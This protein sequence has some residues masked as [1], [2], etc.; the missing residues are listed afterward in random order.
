MKNIVTLLIASVLAGTATSQLRADAWPQW[1]GPNRNFI[2][3]ARGLADAWPASGPRVIW[4]RPLGTGHS[5]IVAADGR[6]FTMYRVGNGRTRQGPWDAEEIVVALDAATGRTIWEY[7][8]PSKREDFSFGA[9]PHS[10]PI[11]V[12]ERL[13]T[14]GTNKQLHAFEARTGKLLWSH[15]LVKEFNSPTL[16]IRPVVK[17]GYGCSPIAF[18]DTII[19]SA[20]GPGQSVMAFRQRDGSVAWKSGD[21]LTSEAP[22]ILIDVAGT[23]QLVVF[24][25]GTV[26]GLDPGTGAVLWSHPHDPG[27]DLNCTTPLWGPDNILFVSSAYKAGSRAIR[28]VRKGD[29]TMPEEVW[30]TSRVRFMFLNALR[31]GDHVYGTTGDFG[32]AFLTAL[33]IKTGRA[34]WQH[35]GFGR[36]SLI[37]ADGKAIILDED[38]DLALAKL[39]P[40]GV[41]ILSEAKLF[42]TTSWTS[43]TLVGT[44]LYARDREKIV[45]LDLGPSPVA[46][47]SGTWKLETDRSTIT[48]ASLAGLAAAGAPPTLHITQPANGTLIVESQI[49]E[50]HTRIYVPGGKTSTPITVGPPGSVTM[51]SRWEGRTFVSEGSRDTTSG[52]SSV[53]TE[54]REAF[55]LSPD[56]R[57]LTIEVTTT[58][59]G[60]KSVS[61]LM[62]TRTKDVG[63]CQSWPTPCKAPS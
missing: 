60:E 16:L 58:T 3:E 12:G 42:E 21:F 34:A 22:P 39:S 4:S 29:A 40:E 44:S 61:T 48:A 53:V 27:N 30:F 54:I 24:G 8:Y 56:S 19:C 35:R 6:L 15:D 13:F 20:G 41:T 32:P 38:G 2:V 52:T 37:Y 62:Y 10:T 59:N 45:A 11:V 43:P 33:D 50:S 26:N 57:T 17:T 28:L 1:G 36:A 23:P 55:S 63:P 5:A 7:R 49:N 18:K 31:L 46:D 51:T 14:F 25:G 47:F 9:G